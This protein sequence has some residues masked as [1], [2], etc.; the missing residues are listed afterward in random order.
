[1]G[2]LSVGICIL[3]V[4]LIGMVLILVSVYVDVEKGDTINKDATWYTYTYRAPFDEENGE[5]A[6]MAV[7]P[8]LRELG[9]DGGIT[10]AYPGDRS[11]SYL[12]I[13]LPFELEA[14][15]LNTI[16]ET[17]ADFQ[18]EPMDI[19]QEVRKIKNEK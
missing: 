11:N 6:R 14:E 5:R 8:Y 13:D 18:F 2:K 4:G 9:W 12:I 1:M 19:K 10:V 15:S 3:V 17:L 16:N 7:I